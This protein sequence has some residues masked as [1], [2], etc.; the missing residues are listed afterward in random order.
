MKRFGALIVV[1]IGFTLMALFLDSFMPIPSTY[2]FIILSFNCMYALASIFS[3]TIVIRLYEANVFE[4]QRGFFD[5]LFQYVYII[6]SGINYYAQLTFRSFPFLIRKI[7][8]V[9]FLLSLMWIIGW[10]M[11]FY[12]S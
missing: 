11:L 1:I 9:A 6:T 5:Y 4:E 8:S 12:E 3:Q 7:L 10:I 2:I